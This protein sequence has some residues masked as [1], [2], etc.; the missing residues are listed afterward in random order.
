MASN[1]AVIIL[2]PFL[3]LLSPVAAHNITRILADFPDFSAFN[4]FLSQSSV[5]AEI[6]RRQTITVLVVDNAAAAPLSSLDA[7]TLKSVLSIHVILDYFDTYK[8]HNLRRRT[9]LFTT[10]YQTT[11]VA[12][13]NMGFLNFTHL[14]DDR[15]AFGSGVKGSPLTATYVKAVK[16]MPYN[17]SVL[18]ITG[19]VV[20]PGITDAPLA[21]FGAPITV[22][23]EPLV[24]APAPVDD[25]DADTPD[26][27]APAADSP[28]PTADSPAPAADSPAPASGPAGDAPAP[29]EADED[30]SSSA[31]RIAGSI[32]AGLLTAVAGALML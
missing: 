26:A 14:P 20:P 17:I 30:D 12:E 29:E 11:G 18:Q 4:Q 16:A 9:T 19:A 22:A 24:P 23:P 27:D 5:A 28:A 15:L 25:S 31:G 21:P 7:E 13:N 10:L 8:I 2:L 3:L 32:T 1:S 6:N